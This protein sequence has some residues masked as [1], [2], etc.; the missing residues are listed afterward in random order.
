MTTE[1]PAAPLVHK[2][3]IA[4]CIC[5]CFLPY[6]LLYRC[7]LFMLSLYL[8]MFLHSTFLLLLPYISA[9]A[10]KASV[11]ALGRRDLVSKELFGG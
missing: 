1:L 4:I 9:L 2:L 8:V 11:K 6:Y 3:F 7:R 5:L 10:S